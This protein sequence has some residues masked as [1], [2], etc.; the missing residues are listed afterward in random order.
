M[1]HCLVNKC[2]DNSLAK[3]LLVS[4]EMLFSRY[5][6]FDLNV[7]MFVCPSCA[8]EDLIVESGMFKSNTYVLPDF[9]LEKDLNNLNT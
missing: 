7:D 4:S 8:S 6:K 3:S 2:K 5:K 9:I 1:F